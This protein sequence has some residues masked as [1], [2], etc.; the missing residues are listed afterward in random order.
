M[1][2]LA[3]T[4]AFVAGSAGRAEIAHPLPRASPDSGTAPL[5]LT[6]HYHDKAVVV[7]MASLTV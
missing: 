4:D 6:L 7:L 2:L 1:P 3:L 5:G